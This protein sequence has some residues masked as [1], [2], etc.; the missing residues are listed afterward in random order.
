M[1]RLRISGVLAG[2]VVGLGLLATACGGPASGE[3][4]ASAGGS[5]AKT[6]NAAAKSSTD[7]Q[8]ASLDFAQCMRE[9]GVDMPDPQIGDGGGMSFSVSGSAKLADGPATAAAG[10]GEATFGPDSEAFTACRHFLDGVIGASDAPPDP[11]VADKALKFAQ[12]MRDHGVDMPDPEVNGGMVKVLI[13][14]SA[15]AD[16]ATVDAAQQACSSIMGGPG[17]GTAKAGGSGLRITA[18]GVKS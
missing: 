4:V 6:R 13:G 1:S 2:T 14:P 17:D 5:S 18:G 10:P 11:A 8:Q 7:P 15:T 12:C 9:H 16:P 3:G